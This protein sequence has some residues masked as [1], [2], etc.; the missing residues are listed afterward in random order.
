[1]LGQGQFAG[2]LLATV[3][4]PFHPSTQEALRLLRGEVVLSQQGEE[5]ET[6]TSGGRNPS[7]QSLTGHR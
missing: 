4:L 6:D 1:M 5:I 7:L 2:Q 3:A